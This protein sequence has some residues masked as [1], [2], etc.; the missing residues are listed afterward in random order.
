MTSLAEEQK[1]M[2]RK[3]GFEDSLAKALDEEAAYSHRS[4]DG[5]LDRLYRHGKIKS[6]TMKRL[7]GGPDRK[8]WNDGNQFFLRDRNDRLFDMHGAPYRHGRGVSPKK[9]KTKRRRRKKTRRK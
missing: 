2:R 1:K 4:F 6:K 3:F 7:R 9:K 5:L 8:S